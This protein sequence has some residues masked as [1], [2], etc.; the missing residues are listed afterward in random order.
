MN[1]DRCGQF[2]PDQEAGRERTQE[3]N[4]GLQCH[5]T[6]LPRTTSS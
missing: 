4:Q 6:F 5:T 3:V 1:E 2:I